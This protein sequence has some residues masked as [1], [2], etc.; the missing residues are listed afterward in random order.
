MIT[1]NPQAADVITIQLSDADQIALNTTAIV[2]VSGD[3][4]V[5]WGDITGTLSDQ[6][7][8]QDA[9]NI[10]LDP[11]SLSDAGAALPTDQLVIYRNG[12]PM[13]TTVAQLGLA[14]TP[15]SVDLL[16]MPT[17]A[18]ESA[19]GVFQRF[20]PDATDPLGYP[21]YY[22]DL[23]PANYQLDAIEVQFK[24]PDF[25]VADEALTIWFSGGDYQ[26]TANGV[27]HNAYLQCFSSAGGEGILLNSF[28][29]AQKDVESSAQ[30]DYF[31][32][33]PTAG[34]IATLTFTRSALSL[35]VGENTVILP[36]IAGMFA[37]VPAINVLARV[38]SAALPLSIKVLHTE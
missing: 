12:T 25:T 20:V 10:S 6:T 24:W 28:L 5:A 16:L 34:D 35:S 32:F 27:I 22:A 1:I 36:H 14:Q 30:T 38:D 21:A 15:P 8:L 11:A 9:L 37:E 3:A 23:A 31:G 2:L 29:G 19:D 18:T 26:S 7:D 33:S 13:R 4:S 17:G